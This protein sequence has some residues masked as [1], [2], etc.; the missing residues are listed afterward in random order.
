MPT[1][2]RQ[3]LVPAAYV[4]RDQRG[5]E[6]ERIENAADPLGAY[7]SAM[8]R[9]RAL[10]AALGRTVPL[11]EADPLFLVEPTDLARAA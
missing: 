8:R 1:T 2:M 9:V 11:F 3:G 4:I 5:A 6:I 10:Y 7:A